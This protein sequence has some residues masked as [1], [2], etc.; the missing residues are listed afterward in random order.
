MARQPPAFVRN[1]IMARHINIAHGLYP[2]A[3]FTDA[4]LTDIVGYLRQHTG[5][6]GGRTYAG[7][8]VKFEPKELERI[9]LPRIE[10]IHA[11]LAKAETTPQTVDGSGVGIRCGAGE[12]RI[13]Q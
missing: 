8:L 12:A 11:Y 6:T 10:D 4:L 3:P 7:G 13:P 1:R 2:R 9:L 5:I